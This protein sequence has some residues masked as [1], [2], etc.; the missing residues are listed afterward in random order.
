MFQHAS[1]P[2][3]LSVVALL[4]CAFNGFATLLILLGWLTNTNWLFQPISD[5]APVVPVT[6][7]CILMST[8]SLFYL[9]L[10]KRTGRVDLLCVSR[11]WSLIAMAVAA[12]TLLEYLFDLNVGL[13]TLL[14]HD[15]VVAFTPNVPY[16]GRLAPQTTLS[17]L[18]F[19]AGIYWMARNTPQAM[20]DAGAVIAVG[21][22][23]PG[24][25]LVGHFI[26]FPEFHTLAGLSQMSM[27]KPTAALLLILGAGALA[28]SDPQPYRGA[29]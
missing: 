11:K 21:M 29:R 7:I 6:A 27:A 15:R 5:A 22:I 9:L 18:V 14:F 20:R 10:A 1:E 3:R 16:P 26:N 17:F 13:E 8:V 2:R 25:A 24:V 19:S 23:I 4:C 12:I 28:L